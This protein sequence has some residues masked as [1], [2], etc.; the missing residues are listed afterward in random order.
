MK[1]I[2]Y[3]IGPLTLVRW[4]LQ[5]ALK[6]QHTLR[7]KIQAEKGTQDYSLVNILLTDLSIFMDLFRLCTLFLAQW[8]GVCLCVC[9][10]SPVFFSTPLAIPS[11]G[12]LIRECSSI[13]STCFPKFLTAVRRI[14][15]NFKK[16]SNIFLKLRM[17]IAQLIFN[18]LSS[19]FGR[20]Y[21]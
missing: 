14:S 5:R 17:V 15:Q 7:T 4:P 19:S 11:K 9:I 18:I 20:L 10:F 3:D 1:Q 6:V 16:K 8:G 12:R 21:F 2:L 13:M